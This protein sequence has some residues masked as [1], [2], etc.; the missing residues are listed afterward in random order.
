MSVSFSTQQFCSFWLLLFPL[1]LL[2]KSSKLLNHASSFNFWPYHV[3]TKTPS[4]RHLHISHNAPYLRAKILHNLWFLISP[5]YYSRPKRNWKHSLR[6]RRLEVVGTRKNG[7]REGDT[8]GKRE[9][10]PESPMK[11]VS[12][13]FPR[14]RKFPIGWEAVKGISIRVRREKLWIKEN[15]RPLVNV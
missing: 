2:S 6:S 4:I 5:G 7:A 1:L 3:C 13:R 9:R 15:T 10:L 14:V 12:T 8:R 11:I